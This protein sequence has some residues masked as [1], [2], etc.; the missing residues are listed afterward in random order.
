LEF[1]NRLH[2]VMNTDAINVKKTFFFATHSPFSNLEFAYSGRENAVKNKIGEEE[3]YKK[4]IVEK[5]NVHHLIPVIGDNGTGKSHLIRWIHDKILID[6]N[7]NKN[8]F[9][10]LASLLWG[11][12]EW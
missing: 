6:P 4:N 9:I 12:S 5:L 11:V 10:F 1:K 7:I 2:E 3:L 8:E